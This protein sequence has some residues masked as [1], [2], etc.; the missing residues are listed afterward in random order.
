MLTDVRHSWC[1]YSYWQLV[2]A[3]LCKARREC[4]CSISGK[5]LWKRLWMFADTLP[6]ISEQSLFSS[7]LTSRQVFFCS[8]WLK[9]YVN[10]RLV[11]LQDCVLKM[12]LLN[13]HTNSD[14]LQIATFDIWTRRNN[15]ICKQRMKN[16]WPQ[17]ESGKETCSPLV[18]ITSGTCIIYWEVAHFSLSLRLEATS[19]ALFWS[20]E[21]PWIL[22][23]YVFRRWKNL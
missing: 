17:S 12:K 15:A 13:S 22:Q 9:F 14:L 21:T 3:H 19:C 4:I 10:L 8:R 7:N 2:R 6:L 16:Q 20:T 23:L 1:C 5:I 18:R 11:L